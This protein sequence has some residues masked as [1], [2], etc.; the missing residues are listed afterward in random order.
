VDIA[1]D[2]D[3]RLS[4]VARAVRLAQNVRKKMVFAYDEGYLCIERVRV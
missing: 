1:D 2:R 4:E 3:L